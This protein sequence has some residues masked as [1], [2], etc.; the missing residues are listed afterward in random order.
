MYN[1]K[2][3]FADIDLPKGYKKF[4]H[5]ILNADPSVVD[6]RKMGPYY[7]DFGLLLVNLTETDISQTI[8]KSLL[9]VFFGFKLFKL[10]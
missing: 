5:E 6:L 7:Y 10:N 2:F 1:E 4:Q 9:W 3:K 8:A